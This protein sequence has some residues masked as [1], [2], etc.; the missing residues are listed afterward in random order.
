MSTASNIISF[1]CILT[2]TRLYYFYILKNY[3][4]M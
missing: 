1:N 4:G 3:I 2:I